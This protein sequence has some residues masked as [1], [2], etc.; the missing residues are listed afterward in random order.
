MA[1]LMFIAP[2][3]IS[4]FTRSLTIS[5]TIGS[6]QRVEIWPTGH[7]LVMK[8]FKKMPK[9]TEE[10]NTESGHGLVVFTILVN[11]RH[12]GLLHL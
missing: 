9:T 3:I 1:S 7:Q 8:S 2:I 10:L 12:F 4:P 11:K 6:E 5:L